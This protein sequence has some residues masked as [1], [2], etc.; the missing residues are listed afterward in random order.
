[1]VKWKLAGAFYY[2]SLDRYSHN[3]VKILD[4]EKII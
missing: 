3:G 2:N 4:E 1:M